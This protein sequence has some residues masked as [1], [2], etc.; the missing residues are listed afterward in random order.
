VHAGGQTSENNTLS[1]DWGPAESGF[2]GSLNVTDTGGVASSI[3][4]FSRFEGGELEITVAQ[5]APGEP[6]DGSVEV[7]NITLLESPM[8]ANILRFGSL[9]GLLR[10]LEGEGLQ[11]RKAEALFTFDDGRLR[12]RGGRIYGEGIGITA[13]G[14]VEFDDKTAIVRGSVAPIATIQR[15]IGKIPLLGKVLTG[16]N[17]EGI[18]A[19]LFSVR[20]PFDDLKVEAQGMSTLTPG[21]TREL[22]KLHP[23]QKIPKDDEKPEE[24]GS[25]D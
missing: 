6:F 9:T 2:A 20:G 7:R 17:E 18:I 13:E 16:P 4:W 14:V 10:M 24:Q 25:K 15:V 23:D 5:P 19:T 8:L 22:F 11:F 3:G 1:A 21:I 12:I